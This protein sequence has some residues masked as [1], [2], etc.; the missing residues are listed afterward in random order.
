MIYMQ[1]SVG[2]KLRTCYSRDNERKLAFSFNKKKTSA[3]KDMISFTKERPISRRAPACRW[4][5][6]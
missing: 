4:I 1:Y 6:I 5:A 3:F 2:H